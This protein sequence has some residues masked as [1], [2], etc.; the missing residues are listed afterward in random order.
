MKDW[1]SIF[2]KESLKDVITV[3]AQDNW[4]QGK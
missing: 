3:A 2:Q 1:K 4:A